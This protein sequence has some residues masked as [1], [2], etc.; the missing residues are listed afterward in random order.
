M[1]LTGYDII[2]FWVARMMMFG[3]YARDD[4]QPFDQVVLTGLIRDRFGKKMSKSRGNVVDPLDWMDSYGSDAVR[5]SLTRSANPGAD[6]AVN[7]EWVQGARAFCNKLW[8]A[9]RFALMN[10]ATVSAALPPREELAAADRWIL[11][12]LHQTVAD[13]D[14]LYEDFQF[15]RATQTLYHF[16]W[17]EFCDWYVELAKTPLAEGGAAADR[18][19]AVLG[20]VL[21]VRAPP[22]AP[23]GAVRDRVALDRA[24]RTGVG[25]HRGVAA[26]RHHL[27]ETRPRSGRSRH[28]R[29][30]SPRCAGSAATRASNRLSESSRG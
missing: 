26:R 14:A 5:F 8:N 28:C 30:S 11:S 18:T 20:H 2:F 9:T 15:G 19:R 23:G 24:H 3:L 17:D 22:A 25:R 12:R 16:A 6:Q 21:D 29:R 13:V 4:V 7:E 1:L 10:G 27:R